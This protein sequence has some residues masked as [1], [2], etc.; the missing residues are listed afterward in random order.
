[1]TGHD[2]KKMSR[3]S[4]DDA[5]RHPAIAADSGEYMTIREGAVFIRVSPKTMR[6]KMALGILREGIHYVRRRGLGPRFLR[7]ALASWIQGGDITQS[8]TT[9]RQRKR[10]KVDLS[11]LDG[12][13]VQS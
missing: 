12:I 2:G 6:N 1:M 7:S 8:A 9:H 4:G 5:R 10:I 11:L 13:P 3:R